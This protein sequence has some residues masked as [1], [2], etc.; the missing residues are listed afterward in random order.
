MLER[1]YDAAVSLSLFPNRG[2][3]GQ[4]PGTRELTTVRPYVIVYRVLPQ[5]VEI[6]RIFHGAQDR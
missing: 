4:E 3:P 5:V 1:L 6:V 2:R